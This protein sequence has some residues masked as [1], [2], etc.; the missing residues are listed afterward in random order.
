M[1]LKALDVDFWLT[2]RYAYFTCVQPVFYCI[3]CPFQWTMDVCL[4]TTSHAALDFNLLMGTLMSHNQDCSLDMR[5][6]YNPSLGPLAEASPCACAQRLLDRSFIEIDTGCPGMLLTTSGYE[7]HVCLFE[8]LN[9]MA[10][11]FTMEGSD[12]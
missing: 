12:A 1:Q 10:T 11:L 8:L 3:W 7:E 6:L 2:L 5:L 4:A 9:W